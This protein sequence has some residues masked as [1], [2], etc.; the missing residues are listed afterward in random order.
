LL[1]GWF[2]RKLSS[3]WLV[4]GCLD[5]NR[6]KWG[7]EGCYRESGVGGKLL[8]SLP[9]RLTE[10]R[11]NEAFVKRKFFKSKEVHSPIQS[12]FGANV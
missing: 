3:F 9:W 4:I 8:A 6:R 2:K 12:L 10:R 11:E 5:E 7:E 1:V